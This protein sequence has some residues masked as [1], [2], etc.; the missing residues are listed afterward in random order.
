MGIQIVGHTSFLGHTGYNNHSRNFFTHLDKFIP[1]KIRNFSHVD[2]LSYLKPE[3]RKILIDPWTNPPYDKLGMF[4]KPN[5]NDTV[6]NI[7]LNESH[8]YYFYDKYSNPMIAYNVWESTRQLDEYFRRILEYDQFWCPTEWQRKC[9]IEQGYPEDRVK[10]VPE[11][12]NGNIFYPINNIEIA[13]TRKELCIKYGLPEDS[14][15][16]MV[17]GRWDYRKSIT[18]IVR[19]FN[20]EFRNDEK[21]YLILSADNPFATDNLKSTEERLEH[22]NLQNERIKVLHFPERDEYIKWMKSGHVFLS[23]SRSEGWNLPL[24]EAI[25]CGTPSICSNWGAQLEFADGISYTVD[26]PT[27]KKP[28]QVFLLGDDHDL[29]MWGEP[30]FDHLKKVMRTACN[31]YHT[32]KIRATKLSKFVRDLYTWD[33]AAIKAK[34]YIEDLVKSKYT[35][36][37]DIPKPKEKELKNLVKLNLGCGNEILPGYINIDRYNNTGV[38]DVKADLSDLPF[39]SETVDEIY[40]SHV[41]EHIGINDM[42]AVLEEWRRVLTV[43]GKLILK[44]PNLEREVKIWLDAPDEKKWSEV[45]RIFGS[46]THEGNTHF[47]G[48]NPGSL[49]SFLEEF[50]F[51]VDSA[52]LG[53]SGHGEEIQCVATKLEHKKLLPPRFKCHFVDGPFIEV[54]GDPNDKGYYRYDFLDPDNES[55]VHQ[56]IFR[57]NH[58]T[59]PYRKYFTNWLVQVKRNG[60]MMFEHKFDCKAKNVLIGLD[61]KS[62]GDTIAWMPYVDEFRKKHNCIVWVS[63]FWNNLF[64]DAYPKLHFIQPGTSV[65][66]VYASYKVGCFDNDPNQNKINWRLIPLQKVASDILGLDYKEIIPNIGIK[67]GDRSIKEKYVTLSQFS[68]LQAKFWNYPKGWQTVVDYLNDKGFRVAVV[69]KE[70]T[71]LKW[72]IDKTN[73]PIEHTINNIYHSEMFIGVSAGPSWLAWAL[74]VPTILI[75]GYSSENAEFSTGVERIINKDVCNS[76]FNSL[77]NRFDR[78]DWN[79]CPRLKGTERQFECSKT[80]KPEVVIESIENILKGKE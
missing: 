48:F 11:G 43:G 5:Q 74:R 53:N 38:V 35:V 79:W 58:W 62:M 15:L 65:E 34:S 49:K 69:S 21:I 76:C 39:E 41:F 66:N 45:K 36:I 50:D 56:D 20:E 72:V 3:E 75:S 29:G 47:C 51:N 18:E 70:A 54:I 77:D 42:Y 2:S 6:V 78:G 71:N 22:H 4:F 1:T 24:I 30:D 55:S 64:K 17:F 40:T 59:R 63:S 25:A 80:I 57:V 28:E 16:F 13:K 8:H 31:E 12:I 67:P 23:C 19:A 26:V 9:T 7:V 60:K 27:E 73:R 68:T 44:L 33:N 46:Q 52:L 37:K 61:S 32:S 10:V 14:F